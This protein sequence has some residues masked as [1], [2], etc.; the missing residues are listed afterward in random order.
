VNEVSRIYLSQTILEKKINK[1]EIAEKVQSRKEFLLRQNK[2]I[3][4]LGASTRGNTILQFCNLNYKYFI[5]AS[6]R[7]PMKK[8]LLLTQ[9]LSSVQ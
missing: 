6:D 3:A 7:N 4:I 5:G 1:E 2:T 9:L 8:G